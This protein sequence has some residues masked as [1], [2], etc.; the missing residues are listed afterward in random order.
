M[1]KLYHLRLY[2]IIY[3]LIKIIVD[4]TLGSRLTGDTAGYLHLS[5][6][7]FYTITIIINLI[8]FLCGLLFFHFLLEKRNWARVVLL[9]IGWL[10]VADFISSLF[11][12]SNFR[13]LVTHI[14]KL[15]D[16]DNLMFIDRITDFIGLIYWGYAIFILQFNN[17]V[18]NLFLSTGPVESPDQNI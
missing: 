14:D 6:A 7:V 16:W 13:E 12:S 10:A 17:E 5:P 1:K 8:L 4:I 15:V 11:V 3:F 9:I 18:K 2:F